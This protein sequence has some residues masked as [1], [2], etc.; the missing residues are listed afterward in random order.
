M[1]KRAWPVVGRTY[2]RAR[3]ADGARAKLVLSASMFCALSACAATGGDTSTI[4]DP[5]SA[6]GTTAGDAGGLGA[7]GGAA[8]GG[9]GNSAT[10]G[11][12]NVDPEDPDGDG[13]C[14]EY[15][16]LNRHVSPDMLI[17]LDRSASMSPNNNDEM[18]DRWA[19]SVDGVKSITKKLDEVVA[20]GL[21]TFPSDSDCGAGAVEVEV[22]PRKASEISTSLGA[23]QPQGNTPTT[24]SLKA[25][26]QALNAIVVGPDGLPHSKYVVLV[27]DGEPNCRPGELQA[28]LA[29]G[30]NFGCIAA[31]AK[32]TQQ[33]AVAVV[34]AMAKDGIKTYV[35][36][37]QTAGSEGLDELAKAGDTGDTQHR[38]VENEAAL[39]AEFERIGTQAVSC[40]F[41]LEKAPPDPMHVL[42]KVDG[43]QLNLNDPNGWAL[44][45]DGRRVTVV[46]SACAALQDGKDHAMTVDVLCRIVTPI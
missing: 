45:A 22:G 35:L 1:V 41:V 4:G 37:Y 18:V 16:V 27:T 23:R 8:S 28:V 33:E 14:D 31:E 7:N 32:K 43:K 20:F 36:G 24:D 3:A 11:A 13:V 10:N 40:D 42:V 30:T 25:A 19:G 44:S 26:Q 34:Q 29:C 5:A 38:A 46:G 21:M 12:S 15:A 6:D 9:T 39:V 2:G 17:V